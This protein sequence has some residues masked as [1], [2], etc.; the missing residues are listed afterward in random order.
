MK[1]RGLYIGRFNPPHFG[2]LKSLEFII[3]DKKIDELFIGI[4][5]AQ[6]SFT[7]KNP[8]TS[9][10]RFEMIQ[11]ALN[12]I[13]KSNIKIFI[14]PLLDLNNNNQWISYLIS[15]LPKFEIIYSNNPLVNILVSFYQ[16]SNILIKNI[17]LYEREKYSSTNIKTKIM[18]DDDS[19]KDLVP[20]MIANYILQL[21]GKNRIKILFSNDSN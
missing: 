1:K 3:N 6:E 12:E 16:G 10:E 2:H 9:G 18:N 13:E 20:K 17:P 11:L 8:F 14:V 4:G 5:S 15:L 21:D 19:W 7:Q